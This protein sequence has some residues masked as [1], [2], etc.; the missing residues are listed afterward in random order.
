M[1]VSVTVTVVLAAMAASTLLVTV[2]VDL[3]RVRRP[4]RYWLSM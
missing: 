1:D 4:V 3:A 2:A